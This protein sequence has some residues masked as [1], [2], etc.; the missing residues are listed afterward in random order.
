MAR[1]N[2]SASHKVPF[3]PMPHWLLKSSL[4]RISSWLPNPVFWNRIFQKFRGS[5][6]F[7]DTD[8][9]RK[10]GE[11]AR[12]RQIMAGLGTIPPD[13]TVLELGTG[14][15]P[16]LVIGHYL[17]GAGPITSFDI[18]PWLTREQVARTLDYFL[19]YAAN[20]ELDPLLPGWRA[21]RLPALKACAAV[22]LTEDPDPL[23][24]RLGI[25]I[26][27]QDAQ[28]TGLPADSVDLVFSSGVLEYIPEA[29]VAGLLAEFRRVAKAAAAMIHRINLRDV[30]SYFDRRLSPFHNLRYS[31]RAW[32]WV[33]SPVTPQNRLR[34]SDYRRLYT[35]A[36]WAIAKEQNELGERADLR[37]VPL[38]EQFR[39][40][41]EADLLVLE[42]W[43]TG[44]AT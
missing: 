31:P 8:F 21:D 11:V 44:R 4:H 33:D 13:Y 18:D 15:F 25:E 39:G 43:L 22:V 38:A 3:Y 7:S 41:A 17:C 23:L 10:L 2:F 6:R 1:R 34:I 5:L 14:W 26:F 28:R 27:V 35:N 16:A 24:K 20:G 42:S 19:R 37:K 36:G 29:I 9:R 40:Y 32:R 12:Q 30:Y